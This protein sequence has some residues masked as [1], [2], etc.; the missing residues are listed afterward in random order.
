MELII[1]TETT[2][3]TRL[4]FANNFNYSQW[5]R[6]V[7]LAWLLCQNGTII[8]QGHALI[9]PQG[10]EIPLTATQIHAVTQKQALEH[11]KDL[12]QQLKE[13]NAVMQRAS[14]LVAHNLNFDLGILESESIRMQYR[15]NIPEKRLCTVHLGRQ[16]MQKTKGCKQ[17]GYPK[18]SQLYETLFGFSYGPMH[19]AHSDAFA[20]LHVF[21]QLK[22]LGFV[23]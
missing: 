4:S 15:L 17:G 21:N 8:E 7:Q 19:Q 10:F 14:T 11:G 9:R 18:L 2:G 13:L 1:D 6:L 22:N 23:N 12:R 5:P 3:L 20:C 16:Y